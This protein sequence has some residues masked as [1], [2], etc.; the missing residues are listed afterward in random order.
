MFVRAVT[1]QYMLKCALARITPHLYINT[2]LINIFQTDQSKSPFLM[3]SA[4]LIGQ[5]DFAFFVHGTSNLRVDGNE[6]P[7]TTSAVIMSVACTTPR[8]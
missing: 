4:I 6:K 7:Y 3:T 1:V 8:V 2:V 5:F